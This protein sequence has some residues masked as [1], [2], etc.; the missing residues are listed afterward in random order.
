MSSTYTTNNGIELIPQGGADGLNLHELTQSWTYR[1]IPSGQ[2]S[3]T[4]NSLTSGAPF[5]LNIANAVTQTGAIMDI[6]LTGGCWCFG[7]IRTA[8]TND[9]EKLV[10]VRNN[11]SASRSCFCFREL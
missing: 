3:I 7:R 4:N 1:Y 8:Y 10:F 6:V 2:V 5:S 11:L 9:A